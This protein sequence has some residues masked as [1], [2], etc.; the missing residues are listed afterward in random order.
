VAGVA[1]SRPRV[2]NG[3]GVVAAVHGMVL[4][5]RGWAHRTDSDGDGVPAGLTSR[6]DPTEQ[7]KEGSRARP[8]PLRGHGALAVQECAAQCH[9]ADTGLAARSPQWRG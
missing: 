9:G 6:V 5:G 2:P 4:Q 3:V 1:A 8:A 7:L